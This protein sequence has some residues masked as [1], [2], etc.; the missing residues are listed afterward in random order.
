MTNCYFN[1]FE[2]TTFSSL[3]V[4]CRCRSESSSSA[5][6]IQRKTKSSQRCKD[7]KRPTESIRD[8][9]PLWHREWSV[10]SQSPLRHCPSGS[11]YRPVFNESFF[12]RRP[13]KYEPCSC[14]LYN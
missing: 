11:T 14:Y 4:C 9:S 7:P 6:E 1:S 2:W 13:T 8:Q 12:H 10:N 5:A 3:V